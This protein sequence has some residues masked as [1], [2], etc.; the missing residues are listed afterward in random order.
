MNRPD[1]LPV[2]DLGVRA[3]LRTLHGLTDL[4]KPK[5]CHA[6]AEHWRPFRTVASWYI[7]QNVDTPG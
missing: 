7:W 4:P 6:L 5:E 3:A 2:H 1:V